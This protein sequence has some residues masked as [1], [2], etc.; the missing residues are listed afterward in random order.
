MNNRLYKLS[1]VKV[2]NVQAADVKYVVESAYKIALNYLKQAY[3]R[4]QKLI[5][6]NDLQ[7]EDI[8]IDSIAPLFIKNDSDQ[9]YV[10]INAYNN[11][12]P[13]IQ[14]EEEA[15]FFLNKI[16]ASR[17]EQHVT[18]LLRESDPVFGK[19]LDSV[20]YIIKKEGCKKINYLGIIYAVRNNCKKIYG[21]VID[22][23]EFEN[24]PSHLFMNK[25]NVFNNLSNHIENEL[26]YF[27]A[28]P[29][30][31]FMKQLKHI[32]LSEYQKMYH[33]EFFYDQIEI[34]EFVNIGLNKAQ[35][36]LENFYLKNKKLSVVEFKYFSK[37]LSDMAADLKNGGIKHGLFDYLN[38]YF[39]TLS[40]KKYNLKYRDILEYELKIMKKSIIASLNA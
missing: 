16:V 19:I 11:W 39:P 3:I 15:F 35:E 13:P 37:A 28:I 9:F 25:K 34:E 17:I 23:E 26:G 32:T 12:S 36:K 2:Q 1:K 4:Y 20:N 14:T 30:F 31:S 7:L 40:R 29:I 8:A 33:E 22:Q 27:P 18:V 38:I 24:L 5:L 6:H 21:R 10:L